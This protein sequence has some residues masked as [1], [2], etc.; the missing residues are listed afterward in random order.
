MT[1]WTTPDFKLRVKNEELDLAQAETVK[2][3]F[4][5]GETVITKEGD[6]LRIDGNT[7]SVWLTQEEAGRFKALCSRPSE[8]QINWTYLAEDGTT[9]KRAATAI[10]RYLVTRNLLREVIP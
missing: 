6:A 9:V 7:V 3:T 8:V 4:A 5:Q 2:V 1:E 10:C